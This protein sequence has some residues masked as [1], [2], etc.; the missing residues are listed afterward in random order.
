VSNIAL[1][2]S[3]GCVIGA[4]IVAAIGKL[5]NGKEPRSRRR[6]RRPF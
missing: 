5:S 3:V 6:K 1:G 4:L 2:F